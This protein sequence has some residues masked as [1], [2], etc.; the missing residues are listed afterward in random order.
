MIMADLQGDGKVRGKHKIF[1]TKAIDQ[2][3]DDVD[4]KIVPRNFNSKQT[5]VINTCI[6]E[7][8]YQSVYRHNIRQPRWF[9]STDV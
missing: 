7:Y 3:M 9:Q 5:C 1:R 8:M 2:N 4:G 6:L